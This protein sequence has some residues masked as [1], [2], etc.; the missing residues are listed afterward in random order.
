MAKLT[1]H[2]SEVSKETL[3]LIMN[4]IIIP[5]APNMLIILK[6][7]ANDCLPEKY[8]HLDITK[9]PELVLTISPETLNAAIITEYKK[10]TPI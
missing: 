1:I 6:D 3:K 10:T 7:Y 8:K 5:Q 2:P 9:F 4:G